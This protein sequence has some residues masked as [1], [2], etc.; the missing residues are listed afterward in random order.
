VNLA[1]AEGWLQAAITE[2]EHA[3]GSSAEVVV[4]TPTLAADDRVA[5]YARAYRARLLDCLRGSF[6]GLLHA[7]G[8][9]L[10]TAFALDY[11]KHWPPRAASLD[12]LAD[13]LPRHLDRTRPPGEE[14]PHFVVDLASLELLCAQVFDGPGPE[15]VGAGDPNDVMALTDAEVVGAVPV[16]A[17]ALRTFTSRYP[18][19]TYL[20][21][22]RRGA[23]PALPAPDRTHV[24]ITR[25]NYRVQLFELSAVEHRALSRVDGV[26]TA[27]AAIGP[28]SPAALRASLVEW[29]TRGF[30]QLEA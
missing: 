21:A 28:A 6:P 3:T 7:L 2:P 10:F 22:A 15:G 20:L 30:I 5:I 16:P 9:G 17:P 8:D 14:W 25:R 1:A 12:R 23:H 13:A 27:Q 19:H 29:T 18:V 11:I 4:S 24:A 26:R